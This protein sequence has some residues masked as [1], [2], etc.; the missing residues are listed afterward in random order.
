LT[1]YRIDPKKF[2][3]KKTMTTI[4][5]VFTTPENAYEYTKMYLMLETTGRSWREQNECTVLSNY[6]VECTV[7]VPSNADL[8]ARIRCNRK[9]ND[10]SDYISDIYNF[11]SYSRYS[12]RLFQVKIDK[13]DTVRFKI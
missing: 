10:G 4:H 7:D 5:F 1:I 12:T 13:Y 9:L 2:L 11:Q 8:V 3:K 6:S